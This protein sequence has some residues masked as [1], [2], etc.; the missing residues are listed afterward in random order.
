[1]GKLKFYKY[2]YL[3]GYS[4]SSHLNICKILSSSRFRVHEHIF[5]EVGLLFKY[6]L[7]FTS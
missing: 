4:P 7:E 3:Y 5:G 1:M 6:P 2:N